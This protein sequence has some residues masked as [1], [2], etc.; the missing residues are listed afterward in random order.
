MFLKTVINSGMEKGIVLSRQ[1]ESVNIYGGSLNH[2][3][4]YQIYFRQSLF[5]I[6]KG[7][8]MHSSSGVSALK[9][10]LVR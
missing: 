6:E 3:Q 7:N 4:N 10:R 9:S 1:Q 8:S 5:I 2:S